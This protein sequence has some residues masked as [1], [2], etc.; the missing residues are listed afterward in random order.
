MSGF[1]HQSP[2]ATILTKN[3]FKRLA[4]LAVL[5]RFNERPPA[6]IKVMADTATK[7]GEASISTLLQSLPVKIRNSLIPN[8]MPA[9]GLQYASH[10]V[11]LHALR[12]KLAA[13]LRQID[14]L[15]LKLRPETVS[16]LGV[17]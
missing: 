11:E 16:N 5:K 12:L 14:N 8:A 1:L 4:M 7:A 6:W 9:Q 3:L 17:L 10:E 15:C 13:N 2:T